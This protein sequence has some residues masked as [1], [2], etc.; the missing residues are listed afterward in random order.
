MAEED[1]QGASPEAEE[2]PDEPAEADDGALEA[3]AAI[4][5]G[6]D[7]PDDAP[8]EEAVPPVSVAVVNRGVLGQL[9]LHYPDRDVT[10]LLDGEAAI[11]VLTM[12]ARRREGGL[13]DVLNPTL[14]SAASGWV[15]LD[16]QEPLALSWLPG[17]PS[18]APRT[19]VDPAVAAG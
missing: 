7:T 3:P 6:D 2:E 17:L 4:P 5:E 8:D 14:S 13:G 9:V 11:R 1:V 18:R 19:A 12:F 10:V 16:L 15:V